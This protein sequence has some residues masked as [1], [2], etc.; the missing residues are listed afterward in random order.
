M[1][2]SQTTATWHGVKAYQQL[3][4]S[5]QWRLKSLHSNLFK[6]GGRR[7]RKQKSD[8][9]TIIVKRSLMLAKATQSIFTALTALA[10]ARAILVS[11]SMRK[12]HNNPMK[13]R[14]KL[15]KRIL[16][17]SERAHPDWL[18]MP[19]CRSF[20]IFLSLYTLCS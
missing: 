2:I 5:Q 12:S 4:V 20:V 15:E 8:K 14:Q 18:A 13:D 1:K 10:F 11:K 3:A 9:A 17:T 16:G 7:G 19:S 6:W